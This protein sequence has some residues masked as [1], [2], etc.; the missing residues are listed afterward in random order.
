MN[1][2]QITAFLQEHWNLVSL[3]VGVVVLIGA[4]LNWNWL[5]DPA[6]APHSHR[7]GRGSRW[8][9]FFLMGVVLIVT[10]IMAWVL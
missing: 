2:E 1:G 8:V 5:C 10:S 3:A 6:G 7:Y 4:I 9:I